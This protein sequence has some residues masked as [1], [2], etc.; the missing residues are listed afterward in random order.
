MST[1]YI[2]LYMANTEDMHVIGVYTTY[3]DAISARDRI[4]NN[5]GSLG[6][7]N[8]VIW[9]ESCNVNTLSPIFRERADRAISEAK[10]TI[11]DMESLL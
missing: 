5:C 10:D 6:L 7:D 8:A 4:A 2:I 3:S 11:S 1:V 9:M